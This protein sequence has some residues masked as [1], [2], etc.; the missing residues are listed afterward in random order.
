MYI[1][2][3]LCLFEQDR[4]MHLKLDHKFA[5]QLNALHFC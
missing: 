2:L 1:N 5:C 4:E 3:F